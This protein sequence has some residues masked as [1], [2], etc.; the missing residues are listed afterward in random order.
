MGIKECVFVGERCL[1]LFPLILSRCEHGTFLCELLSFTEQTM[2]DG[3]EVTEQPLAV[4]EQLQGLRVC[5]VG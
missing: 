3:P 4:L 2:E 5:E 1:S